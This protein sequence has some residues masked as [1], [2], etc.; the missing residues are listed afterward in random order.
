[1]PSNA[2]LDSVYAKIER[3]EHHRRNFIEAERRFL[4]TKP[5]TLVKEYEPESG[6][7]TV[8]WSVRESPPAVLALGLADCLHNL[9]A[10]L[11]YL[12]WQL[13]VASGATPTGRTMFPICTDAGAKNQRWLSARGDR[14]KGVH[15]DWA[16]KIEWFQPFQPHHGINPVDHHFLAVLDAVNNVH[17]H[18]QPDPFIVTFG[19]VHFQRITLTAGVIEHESFTD[20]PIEDGAP[21]LRMRNR[22]VGGEIHMD[23]NA[24][25]TFRV[26]FDDGIGLPWTQLQLIEQVR[27]L[28]RDFEPAF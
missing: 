2:S 22:D 18:R 3:A 27:R 19:A 20:R 21:C 23:M 24:N 16:D 28:V 17:K 9:R 1:M 7:N 14:L 5:Y 11:D 6:W 10:A 15:P 4:E 26:T 25:A 12:A 8:R 13:V